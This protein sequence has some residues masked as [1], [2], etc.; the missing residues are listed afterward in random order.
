MRPRGTP[1]WK[2]LGAPLDAT[3]LDGLAVPLAVAA[4]E[5]S[6]DSEAGGSI[7]SFVEQTLPPL[8]RLSHS[9][10]AWRYAMYGSPSA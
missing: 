6:V 1:R 3:V 9:F 8:L 2:F 10:A 7:E 4:A 5:A